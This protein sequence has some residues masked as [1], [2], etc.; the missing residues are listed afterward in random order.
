MMVQNARNDDFLGHLW[1]PATLLATAL[2][3]GGLVALKLVG[4]AFLAA[5]AIV[6][7]SFAVRFTW[8]KRHNSRYASLIALLLIVQVAGV[9]FFGGRVE[10]NLGAIF[11]LAGLIEGLAITAAINA[12]I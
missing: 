6:A 8:P 7:T 10:R 2:T 11:M 4:H 12:L 3:V 1:V 5:T 9:V